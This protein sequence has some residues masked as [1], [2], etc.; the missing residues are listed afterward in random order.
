MKDKDFLPGY[1]VD[2][3][4]VA[5]LNLMKAALLP[6]WREIFK[7]AEA[8]SHQ[9]D[10]ERVMK[11]SKLQQLISQAVNEEI[12]SICAELEEWS[13]TDKQIEAMT[14]KSEAFEATTQQKTTDFVYDMIARRERKHKRFY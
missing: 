8:F 9:I 11:T 13:W 12:K 1:D 7:K 5:T 2:S 6:D 3:D 4:G 10:R 14:N